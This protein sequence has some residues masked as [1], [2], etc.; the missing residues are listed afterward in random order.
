MA[1]EIDF[2]E[3]MHGC[4]IETAWIYS[5]EPYQVIAT[6]QMADYFAELSF[7]FYSNSVPVMAAG[8]KLI[9]F[10]HNVDYLY[11]V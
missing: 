2:D 7:R 9:C 5:S 6:F 1:V 3:I 10:G 8:L 4:I 11:C